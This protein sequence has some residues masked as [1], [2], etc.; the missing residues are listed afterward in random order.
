[1]PHFDH[2]HQQDFGFHREQHAVITDSQTI[3]AALQRL[4]AGGGELIG[5]E[6]V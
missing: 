1:M 3:A 5:S 6:P 2:E 4:D